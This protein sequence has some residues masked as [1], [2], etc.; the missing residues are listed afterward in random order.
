[1]EPREDAWWGRLVLAE[2]VPTHAAELERILRDALDDAGDPRGS[3][4]SCDLACLVTAYSEAYYEAERE[5][6]SERGPSFADAAGALLR[7]LLGDS[8]QRR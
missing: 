1:M 3:D 2:T 8:D 4:L 5:R 7:Q 6:R